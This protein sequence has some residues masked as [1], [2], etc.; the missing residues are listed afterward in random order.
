MHR[1]DLAQSRACRFIAQTLRRLS[2]AHASL[3]LLAKYPEL[4]RF[5]NNW[6]GQMTVVRLALYVVL[7][8]DYRKAFGHAHLVPVGGPARTAQPAEAAT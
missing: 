8:L 5:T 2:G 7:V 3:L 6:P 4:A 1:L